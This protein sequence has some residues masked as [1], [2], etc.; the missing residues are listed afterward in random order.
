MKS[1][2]SIKL[3]T[4]LLLFLISTTDAEAGFFD[5]LGGLFGLD[6]S[7]CPKI[8]RSTP[9]CP[10]GSSR[11]LD[12]T[13]PHKAIVISNKPKIKNNN[14]YQ[15]PSKFIIEV[16]NAYRFEGHK[17]VPQIIVPCEKDRFKSMISDIRYELWRQ[18]YTNENI[19]KI[20][21]KIH[22]SEQDA[23]TWQQDYFESFYDPDTGSPVT[24]K[25]E[26]YNR[27]VDY[28]ELLQTASK[29]GCNIRKEKPLKNYPRS[30]DA[31]EM[32]GNVEGLPAGGCLYG[33]NMDSDMALEFCSNPDD[34]AQVNTGFLQVGHVDEL[35]KI[36]PNRN[37]K[38]APK[39]CQ[40][41]ISYASPA[42]GIKLLEENPDDLLYSAVPTSP[43]DGEFIKN[44]LTKICKFI[45]YSRDELNKNTPPESKGSR[46]IKVKK[47]FLNI[48]NLEAYAGILILPKQYTQCTHE[49]LRNF[50]NRDFLRGLKHDKQLYQLNLDIEKRMQENLKI[51]TDNILR[52]LPH[53]KGH[54]DI[55]PVPDI[56][57]SESL[58]TLY[59]TNKDGSKTLRSKGGN[60]L[61]IFP[62]PTN[63]V[64]VNETMIYSDP[65]IKPFRQYLDKNMRRRN[66]TPRFIP[67][68]EYSHLGH[69]NL[70][71]S[72][73]TLPYCRP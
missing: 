60:C 21:S 59:K 13:Y 16:I 55:L 20:I 73:H 70:H 31:G 1:I 12:D 28:D 42:L 4:F 53:C 2:P 11:I 8:D 6:K 7:P 27:F 36:T 47:V 10:K 15:T 58:T 67:T 40:F 66:N 14:S 68:Y 22:H 63:G 19:D 18:H 57:D 9:K 51:V 65:E 39:E 35:F 62:S 34:H 61:S 17:K 37:N 56:Y 54:L 23:Y 26:S 48:L 50:T 33:N 46:D 64:F 72:S 38:G 29:T 43:D 71:C 41:T 49:E 24:R 25:F 3:A 69:G 44:R 30:F 45:T 5:W 32:G 52:R